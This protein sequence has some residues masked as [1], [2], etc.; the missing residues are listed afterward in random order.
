MVRGRSSDM[1][2]PPESKWFARGIKKLE[3]RAD[4]LRPS[5]FVVLGAFDA[6]VMQ[7]APE[8]PAFLEE[9]VAEFL[10]VVDDARAFARADIEPDARAGL[11]GR[12]AGKAVNDVLIPPD[13][14]REGGDFPKNAR[15][16]QAEIK[17]NEA[18]ER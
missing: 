10:D 2:R 18:A 9:H 3:E 11:H 12:R 14:W 17:R 4:A 15:M 7:I 6:L 13:G 1:R 16:L 8:L 5:R